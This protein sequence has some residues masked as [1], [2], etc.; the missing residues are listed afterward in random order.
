VG[1]SGVKRITYCVT[2]RSHS[3][4]QLRGDTQSKR[5]VFFCLLLLSSLMLAACGQVDEV[6]LP[7][8]V[9][10][11]P[12][13]PT[14]LSTP[15][16]ASPT[17]EIG[18]EAETAVSASPTLTPPACAQPGRLERHTVYSPTS[19]GEI[20]YQIYLPPCYGGE[21]VANGR[22]YPTLYLLPGNI[23][24]ENAWPGLGLQETVETAINNGDIPPLLIVMPAGGWLANNTSGGPGS[25]ESFVLNDLIPH[26][27]TTTCAWPDANGRALGGLSRGGY[28]A[29]G[30]AFR[31]PH[32]FVSVGGHSAALLDTHAGPDVNPQQT[33]LSSDLGDLRIYL[34]I[35]ADDWVIHNIR[36]LHEDM[37]AAGID[38]T[39]VLND[40]SHEE[41]YWTSHLPAYLSWYTAVWSPDPHSYPPCRNP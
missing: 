10:T 39:W 20:A 23:H 37:T 31:H 33:G 16:L 30:I 18:G 13:P 7:T 3:Q 5:A 12:L 8:L 41:A 26:I 36:R 17:A 28:W 34:D 2:W 24:D 35:G 1:K 27:E 22:S 21:G 15:P 11:V 6:P 4:K 29:L 38:H 25:Y 32:Q 19:G 9:A 14:S 40:G